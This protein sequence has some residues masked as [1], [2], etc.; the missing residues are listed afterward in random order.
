MLGGAAGK[1]RVVLHGMVNVMANEAMPALGA[2]ISEG[3]TKRIVEL[4]ADPTRV[5]LWAKDDITAGDGAKH[6]VIPEKGRIATR[7]TA[8]VFALLKACGLP[9]AFEGEVGPD[10]F[11]A[12]KCRMLPYEVVVRR[13]AHGSYLKRSP[14]LSKGHLFSKLLLEFFL[15]TKGRVWK[16]HALVADDP[17]MAYDAEGGRI[18]LY[19]P[20]KPFNAAGAFLTMGAEEV[21]ADAE[22]PKFFA[23][24]GRI[25]RKAFLVLEKA[26]QLQGRKLVDMKVEFGVTDDGRLLLADVIDNDS[27]RV[28]EEGAYI[29]K[30]VYRDGGALADVV[31]KYRH[32]EEL[33]GRFAVPRQRVIVWAGSAKDDVGP[34]VGAVGKFSGGSLE[35]VTVACS[36]HKEPVRGVL[37]LGRLVQEVP[38]AVVIAYIGMSNGA[39]PTLAANTTV[40]VI[41]VPA[42]WE[43]FPEDAWSSLR[44]PSNV[45]VMTVLSAG[46][47]AQAA[48]QILALRNPRLYAE[49]R[50]EVE[51]RAMNVV[52]VG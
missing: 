18:A 7:T 20:A 14:Y 22:E 2:V 34:V 37:E 16:D 28:V 11:V 30:Q 12:P 24:M 10:W 46:N 32:V 45:P 4:Q 38:D 25:A 52:A 36:V 50:Y 29:D 44:G 31:R 26:W 41:T 6:D 51:E 1:D 42:G 8:N 39:G 48:V 49:V 27:W 35:T 21:F 13:E 9:V 15:K 47:A 19:D 33:T 17:L 23:E 5:V 43:K 3:K 40:P